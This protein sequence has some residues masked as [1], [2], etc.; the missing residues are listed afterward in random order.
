[1][2]TKNNIIMQKWKTGKSENGYGFDGI[3]LIGG[4]ER[5]LS[6]VKTSE[7]IQFMEECD[8]FFSET[9]SKEDAL[10][11]IDELRNWIIAT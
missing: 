5:I 11:I 2:P 9:Y 8:G 10:K 4:N 3:L 6:V 1:M 7:G